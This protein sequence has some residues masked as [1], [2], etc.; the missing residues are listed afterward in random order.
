[1]EQ[2]SIG[3]TIARIAQLLAL[4]AVVFFVPDGKQ[5]IAFLLVA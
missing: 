4:A 1:M 2:V 5:L 3:L